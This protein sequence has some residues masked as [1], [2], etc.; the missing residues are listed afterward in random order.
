MLKLF[1]FKLPPNTGTVSLCNLVTASKF[2]LVALGLVIATLLPVLV[3]PLNSKLTPF[4]PAYN[5]AAL[6]VVGPKFVAV[7]IGALTNK[8]LKLLFTRSK[9]VRKSSPV[10]SFAYCPN[11]TGSVSLVMLRSV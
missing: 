1:K 10:P 4:L 11:R 3:K 6:P 9:A 8:S 5:P 7:S 2:T